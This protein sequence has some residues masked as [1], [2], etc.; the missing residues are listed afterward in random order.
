MNLK[1]VSLAVL[2]LST[3]TMFPVNLDAAFV[4]KNGKL[5]DAEELPQYSAEQHFKLGMQALESGCWSDAASQFTIVSSHY[6]VTPFGQEANYHLGVAYYYMQEYDFANTA[7][8]NYLK[9]HN[10]PRFFLET[11]EYKFCIAEQFRCGAKRRFFQTRKMPKWASGQSLALDIYDEVISAAPSTDLAAKALYSKGYVLWQARDYKA[12]ID[13]LQLLIRRF[14]K[15]ELAADCYVLINKVYLD[16]SVQEFQ[17]PD[18]LALAQINMR[19][20]K[21]D[22]PKE[23]R[24]EESEVD[25]QSI[26]EIYAQGLYET[27]LFYERTKKLGASIIYYQKTIREFPDTYIAQRCIARLNCLDPSAIPQLPQE[28]CEE[29]SKDGLP[30]F[31]SQ[32]IEFS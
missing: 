14:P 21:R 9:C 1:K 23:P 6:P 12:A 24:L 16:Q 19:K 7:F 10:D 13:S 18:L 8:S 31:D 28:K 32:D 30:S 4:F 27:G 15:H 29:K 2:F 5:I 3:C 11:I 25:V 20:F 22:F 26:K 17:N